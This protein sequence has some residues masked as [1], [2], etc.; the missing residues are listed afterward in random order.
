MK[1]LYESVLLSH[2][3]NLQQASRDY[4][5]AESEWLDLS[6]GI[7][8]FPWPVPEIPAKLWQQ[9]PQVPVTL[10][11]TA[12]AYYG[13]KPEEVLAVTGSQMLI[14]EIPNLFAACRVAVPE[15]G[16]AEHG[17]AWQKAGHRLCRYAADASPEMLLSEAERSD[18]MVVINPNNPTA[19]RYSQDLLLQLLQRL[20]AHDGLLIVD[21]AF[22]DVTPEQSLAP[23]VSQGNLLI[24]RSLGKFFGL[25]GARIGFALADQP[26]LASLAVALG[27]W[28]VSAPALYLAEQALADQQWQNNQRLRINRE[29]GQLQQ[30]LNACDRGLVV[31]AGLFA[32]CWW[33][34]APQVHDA[35]ARGGIWTRLLD[36]KQGVRMGLPPDTSSWSRLRKALAS[37]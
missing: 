35:L 20:R 16:Y 29:S 8:P 19:D 26:L 36:N 17:A 9:L 7:S 32:T 11:V 3:G 37:L 30:L 5:I 22:M 18:V 21:E 25:A 33:S 34:D 4:Q 14:R 28:S 31:N 15:V 23:C 2:G 27:P 6:T 10:A 12:A 24:M 1:A 13:C